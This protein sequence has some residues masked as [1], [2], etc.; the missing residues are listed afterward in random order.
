VILSKTTVLYIALLGS[1]VITQPAFGRN[2][3]EFDANGSVLNG[4]GTTNEGRDTIYS[5]WQNLSRP[6][7][8]NHFCS[9]YRFG[10]SSG[11]YFLDLKV[12]VGG[13]KFIVARNAMLEIEMECGDTV[14]L[15]NT[16]YEKSCRGCGAVWKESDVH[17]VTLRFPMTSDD[18]AV[19]AHDYPGH[20]RLH[21]P[22]NVAGS[23]FT[24]RRTELFRGEVDR[25]REQVGS[26]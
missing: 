6:S 26:R 14:Q 22:D 19:L 4:S 15:F 9:F 23:Y 18:L 16:K 11:A 3:L 5:D 24:I 1:V 17:G 7:V 25:F 10:F 20:I 8:K 12:S 2:D 21:L 13:V